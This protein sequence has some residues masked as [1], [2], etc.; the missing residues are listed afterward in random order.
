MSEIEN[1]VRREAVDG[2]GFSFGPGLQTGLRL[3][4]SLRTDNR[5]VN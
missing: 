2:F 1:L 4:A 5:S 3:S